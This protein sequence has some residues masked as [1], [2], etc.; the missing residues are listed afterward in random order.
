MRISSNVCGYA[1]IALLSLSG[2]SV[3]AAGA[4]VSCAAGSVQTAAGCGSQCSF[5]SQIGGLIN[6]Q[7]VP[8]I[9]GAAGTITGV[10]YPNPYG[11][12]ALCAS[13]PG[14]YPV[15]MNGQ[16]LCQPSY[17]GYSGSDA[18][19]ANE[20]QRQANA[21]SSIVG[22]YRGSIASLDSG[23][24]LG[25]IEINLQ[26]A[27]VLAPSSDAT[28]TNPQNM[29]L[30]KVKI[31][32]QISGEAPLTQAAYD[33]ASGNLSGSIF[34]QSNDGQLST[35]SIAG[36][37][38]NGTI[39]GK[40]LLNS[41]ATVGGNFNAALNAP[42]PA[43]PAAKPS[44]LAG[45]YAGKLDAS[46]PSSVSS[47]Q[48][49]IRPLAMAPQQSF[50]GL[51]AGTQNSEVTISFAHD[52]SVDTKLSFENVQVDNKN[53]RLAGKAELA[54]DIVVDINL[55]CQATRSLNVALN[56]QL[57][58]SAG[59]QTAFIVSPQKQSN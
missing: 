43:P 42:L 34:V 54:G 35:L 31:T 6:G 58:T 53:G 3:Y 23:A 22:A 48:M 41:D 15:M 8:M 45:N 7:C 30:G 27:L 44:S 28:S 47:V 10:P 12:S 29:I 11:T 46:Q 17:A 39:S 5:G 25:S 4:D 51:L 37:I 55:N 16:I 40:I 19:Q 1:M 13:I 52:D 9:A 20:V 21:T 57:S 26:T 56:C 33:A 18:N 50:L 14:T 2:T 24:Q 59:G 36:N 38:K 32:G 49:T